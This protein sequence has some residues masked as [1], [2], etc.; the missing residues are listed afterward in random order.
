MGT[1]AAGITLTSPNFN[2]HALMPERLSWEAGNVSPGLEWS[3]VPVH[4][5]ASGPGLDGSIE[6]RVPAEEAFESLA[7]RCRPLTL[8]GERV[9]LP[10]VLKSVNAFT[11]ESEDLQMQVE[12][13]KQAWRRALNPDLPALVGV[14]PRAGE[15]PEEL[16]SYVVLAEQWLNGDLVH[17][18]QPQSRV[19]QN[20]TIDRRYIC[21]VAVYGQVA[22]C[23][24]AL[25]KLLERMQ[26][27]GVL[28][29]DPTVFNQPVT[30]SVPL[31]FPLAGARIKPAITDPEKLPPHESKRTR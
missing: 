18:D 21:A 24:V 25:L 16:V 9:H 2:D 7:S 28:G 31:A 19:L 4:I 8:G 6:W 22:L 20:T 29:L 14:T 10:K 23:A 15:V 5:R 13:V 1:S 11:R 3:Q 12:T 30:V 26:E 17:N 27:D